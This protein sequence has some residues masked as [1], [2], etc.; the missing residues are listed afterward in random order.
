MAAAMGAESLRRA[1]S[2]GID[3][4]AE[5]LS[6]F[7]EGLCAVSP[8][9]RSRGLAAPVIRRVERQMSRLRRRGRVFV[10]RYL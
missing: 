3:L 7:Y 8:S 10:R 2:L 9:E 1:E 6:G 5:R 4:M